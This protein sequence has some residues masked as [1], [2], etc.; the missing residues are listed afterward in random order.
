MFYKQYEKRSFTLI[1]LL[2]VIAIIAILASMLLPALGKAREKARAIN[3]MSN[4]KQLGTAFALY[5][6]DNEGCIPPART[7]GTGSMYWNSPKLGSGYLVPYLS[8]LQGDLNAYIG[9]VGGSSIKGQRCKLSCPSYAATATKVFTYGY[10]LILG[11]YSD[12]APKNF[13]RFRK[14]SRFRK[15]SQTCIAGDI[16]ATSGYI[17]PD[18]QTGTYFVSYRHGNKN[19]ANIL[20]ADGHCEAK[21]YGEIPDDTNP[22]WTFSRVKSCFWN[23]LAPDECW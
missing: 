4:F 21:K 10:N 13:A 17:R 7:Y 11:N 9:A 16:Q 22:G 18:A 1:E 5:A 19:Q 20:F 12:A 2:V 23:P 3:C 6:E 14:L 8:M 15:I